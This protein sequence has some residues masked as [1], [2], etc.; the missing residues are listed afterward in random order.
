M[1]EEFDIYQ[2]VILIPLQLH[3]LHITQPCNSCVFQSSKTKFSQLPNG[4]SKNSFNFKTLHDKK[5]YRED[6]Y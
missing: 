5:S 6:I 3:S 1:I 4:K 2:T